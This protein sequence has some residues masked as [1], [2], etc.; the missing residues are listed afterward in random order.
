MTKFQKVLSGLTLLFITASANA[1][2]VEL[3]IEFDDFPNET[4]FGM[5]DAGSA[6]SG[7]AYAADPF[8]AFDGIAYDVGASSPIGFGD[9]YV[10]PGDFTGEPANVPFSFVWDLA[11]GNYTF[12]IIDTFGDGICCGWGEGSYSLSVDGDIVASS[13]G[14]FEQFEVTNFTTAVPE[15][16]FLALFALGLLGVGASQARRRKV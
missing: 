14:V 4:A 1:V 7:A 8:L 15:P 16:G 6:P 13:E 2:I 10:L 5:W 9:G 11:V 12:I 3:V